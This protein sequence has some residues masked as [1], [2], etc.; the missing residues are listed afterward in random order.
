MI[1]KPQADRIDQRQAADRL[2]AGGGDFGGEQAAEGVAGDRGRRELERVE[3]L[4]VIDDEVEPAVERVRRF[5]IAAAGA[6]KF[7]RID[8]VLRG[9]PRDEGAVGRQP[10]R[11]VQINQRRAVA[12]DLD[13]GLDPALPEFQPACFRARHAH[14]PRVQDAA[15][16]AGAAARFFFRRSGHQWSSYLS[17]H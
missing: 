14:S 8:G 15:A 5:G 1:V 11:A 10:P 6:G 12:C 9:E 4:A 13:L 7:R 3:Q 2:W 16:M 17:S